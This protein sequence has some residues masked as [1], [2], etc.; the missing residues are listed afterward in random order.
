MV[1]AVLLVLVPATGPRR[2][3]TRCSP[4]VAPPRTRSLSRGVARVD[5]RA[6]APRADWRRGR[7]STSRRCSARIRALFAPGSSDDV[8][9]DC[10]VASVPDRTLLVV[11]RRGAPAAGRRERHGR[12]R[13]RNA[14]CEDQVDAADRPAGRSG[15]RSRGR[16]RIDSLYQANGYYLA[17]VTP[18]STVLPDGRLGITFRV[19]EGRRLAISGIEFEGN[20]GARAEDRRGRDEDASPKGSVV[21]EGR[22]RRGQ[23]RGRPRRAHPEAVRAARAT[24]ISACSR[25]R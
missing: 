10:D 14:P 21:P 11:S 1:L 19:D 22:V 4:A 8:A 13:C 6:S 3:P 15:R 24:S 25:T 18:D 12:E 5:R 2:T 7:R 23:V 20:A 17:R 9:I 16:A